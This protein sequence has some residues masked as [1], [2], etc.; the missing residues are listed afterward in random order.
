MRPPH[1]HR[2]GMGQGIKHLLRAAVPWYLKSSDTLSA[3]SNTYSR[4]NVCRCILHAYTISNMYDHVCVL[5]L[6]VVYIYIYI[7][8][9]VYIYICIVCVYI[10]KYTHNHMCIYIYIYT[11]SYTQ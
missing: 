4:F 9:Y 11:H 6:H 1:R 8:I 5:C 3:Q 2:E 10:Y 7:H